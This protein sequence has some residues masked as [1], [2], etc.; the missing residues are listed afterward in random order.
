[1]SA[2]FIFQDILQSGVFPGITKKKVD[3]V[4]KQVKGDI[5]GKEDLEDSDVLM[6]SSDRR[7]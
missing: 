3:D 2:R 4:I 5:F 7:K 6:K 1:M